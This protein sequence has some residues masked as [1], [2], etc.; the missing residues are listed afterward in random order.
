MKVV[1]VVAVAAALVVLLVV[2]VG[3]IS[4]GDGLSMQNNST[5]AWEQFLKYVA[6]KEGGTKTEDGQ[7]YIVEDD[8]KGNPTVGHGLCLKSSDGYLNVDAFSSYG[9]DSKQLADNWLNGNR[10]GK[11][12]VEICDAIWE[13]GVKTRYESIVTQYPDLTTYQHYALTDVKYRRGNTDGFQ[14][15]YDSKWKSSDDKYG[16]YDESKEP[17]SMDSLYSFFNNGFTDTSSG[18]YT[19]KQDQWVLFKYGYYRPL[20]EYWIASGGD[21]SIY[22]AAVELH[23]AQ[24]SWSYSTSTLTSGNIEQAINSPYKTT[25]C[26]TYVSSALYKAGYVTESEINS[27][28]YNSSNALKDLLEKKGWEKVTSYSDLQAE[29]IVFMDTD[30][31]IK[32]ITHVQICAEKDGSNYYWFNAGGNNS[33]Q[34][35]PAPYLDNSGSSMFFIAYR[36]TK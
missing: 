4:G 13:E 30:G 22:D 8:S 33:I 5:M 19:R 35:L 31:G 25:C 26:A 16:D 11:V 23:N 10:D 20:G 28:N 1:P 9:I 7:Y 3:A 17:F 29:D 36:P 15:A 14:E 27:I 34:T 2:I 32:D 6:T 12:S 24:T 18:V 21:G